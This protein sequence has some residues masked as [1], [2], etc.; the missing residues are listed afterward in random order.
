[1]VLQSVANL[2]YD[3]VHVIGGL[4]LIEVLINLLLD[5]HL[6]LSQLVAP[7]AGSLAV[8]AGLIKRRR[9]H[10]NDTTAQEQTPQ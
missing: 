10:T 9:K 8:L 4:V 7:G 5:P 1:M 2:L 6:S 3:L